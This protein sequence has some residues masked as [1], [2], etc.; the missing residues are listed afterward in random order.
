M[1]SGKIKRLTFIAHSAQCEF[2]G[3]VSW[4]WQRMVVSKSFKIQFPVRDPFAAAD[5]IITLSL[6]LLL[7]GRNLPL[8][9]VPLPCWLYC[10]TLTSFQHT[11]SCAE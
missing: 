3:A 8:P 1:I 10:S 9:S 7:V 2:R 11:N 6:S 5:G 4:L